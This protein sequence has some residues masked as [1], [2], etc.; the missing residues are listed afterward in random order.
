MMRAPKTTVE[1]MT[2]HEPEQFEAFGSAIQ[3]SVTDDADTKTMKLAFVTKREIGI[4][5]DRG[6]EL[7]Q[8]V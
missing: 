8:R 6:K 7:E 1:C 2:G 3:R 4:E 5:A